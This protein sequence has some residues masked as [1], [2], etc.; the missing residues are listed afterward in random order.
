MDM[1]LTEV[2][3]GVTKIALQGRLDTIGAGEIDLR[4]SAATGARRAVVV[5]MSGVEIMT[6]L[7]VRMLLMGAKTVRNKGGKLVLLSPSPT[8]SAVLTM[9]GTEQLIPVFDD[10]AAAVAAVAG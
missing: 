3:E 8:I 1:T 4:F 6:S 5:D 7:G 10:E 2:R 9:A